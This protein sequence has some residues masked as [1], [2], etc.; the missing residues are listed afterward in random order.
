MEEFLT[1]REVSEKYF[2]NACNYNKV[3]RLTRNGVIPAKKL[4]KSYLYRKVNL[5]EWAAREFSEQKDTERTK[6]KDVD[7]GSK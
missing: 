7:Y 3:L 5:E 4:G 2:G 1:A 6:G